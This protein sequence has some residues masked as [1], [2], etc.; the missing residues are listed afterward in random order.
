MSEHT[1]P[2]PTE[3][4]SRYAEG[5]RRFALGHDTDQETEQL[6][7]EVMT[8]L[9]PLL[10]DNI[11]QAVANLIALIRDSRLCGLEDG[12]R[13]AC[14]VRGRL[15]VISEHLKRMKGE[16]DSLTQRV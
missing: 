10:D 15:A 5:L 13:A 6:T 7:D 9:H 8:A 11:E 2:M 12:Q 1:R 3:F 4:G 14:N 16:V